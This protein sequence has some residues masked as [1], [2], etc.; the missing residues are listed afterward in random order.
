SFRP[1]WN[2]LVDGFGHHDQGKA[3]RGQMKS[4]WDTLHPGRPWADKVERLN[5][6][7]ADEI[8]AEVVAYL[9]QPAL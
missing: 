1:V 4:T 3:R 7:T 9:E 6:K 8:S 2:I 5:N